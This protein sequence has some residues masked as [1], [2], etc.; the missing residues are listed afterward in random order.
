MLKFTPL[1]DDNQDKYPIN[2]CSVWLQRLLMSVLFYLMCHMLSKK[3]KCTFYIWSVI[4]DQASIGLTVCLSA[5]C[6]LL[7][8][9]S[10]IF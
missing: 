4:H 8:G 6:L 10:L 2:W 1:L 3:A 5:P 7:E 9:K